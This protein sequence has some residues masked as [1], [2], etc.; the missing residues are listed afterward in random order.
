MMVKC[1]RRG[2]TSDSPLIQAR[3]MTLTI[4]GY[5]LMRVWVC[6]SVFEHIR[7]CLRHCNIITLFVET[8]YVSVK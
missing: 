4:D 3:K 8:T 1:S 7:L 5:S 6:V 2:K